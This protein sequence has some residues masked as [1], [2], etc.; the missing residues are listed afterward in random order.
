[1]GH[2]AGLAVKPTFSH[3]FRSPCWARCRTPTSSASCSNIHT[4]RPFC[5]TFTGYHAGFAVA[6]QYH[7]LHG[8][9]PR[10]ADDRHAVLFIRVTLL[11]PPGACGEGAGTGT[12]A[13]MGLTIKIIRC[14]KSLIGS[15]RIYLS[16]E[17][18]SEAGMPPALLLKPS[19]HSHPSC[20]AHSRV[21]CAPAVSSPGA[22]GWT[23]CATSRREC[24]ICT[25]AAQPSFTG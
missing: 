13:S 2:L 10:P 5:H 25:H 3:F 6:P 22:S 11:T 17:F 9:Q 7:A 20:S 8:H 16:M 4:F 24:T 21:M 15:N 19:S 23:C 12:R 18:P 14:L 1:M